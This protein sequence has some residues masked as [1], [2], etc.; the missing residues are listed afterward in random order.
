MASSTDFR[1]NSKLKSARRWKAVKKKI[2]MK[3]RTWMSVGIRTTI[4]TIQT[5]ETIQT[6]RIQYRLLKP[7]HP[8]RISKSGRATVT[9]KKK[10]TSSLRKRAKHGPGSMRAADG[11]NFF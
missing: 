2:M 4:Q 1:R 10:T 7:V 8:M 3:G 9:A 6:L 11:E 5:L